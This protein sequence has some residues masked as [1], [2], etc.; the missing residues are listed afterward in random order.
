MT[1][2]SKRRSSAASSRTPTRSRERD[3][4]SG[5]TGRTT[6]RTAI[7]RQARHQL[8]ELLGKETESISAFRTTDEGWQL[9]VEV[10]EVP[11]VPDTTSIL[12]TYSVQLD[13]D[14]ELVGY[15]RLARYARGQIGR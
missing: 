12:G 8:E 14:G 3:T 15:E 2:Q 9:N 13:N 7:V 6:K 5:G 1:E 10:V 4:E 11:R